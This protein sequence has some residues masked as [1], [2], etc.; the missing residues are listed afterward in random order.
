M[1]SLG[2]NIEVLDSERL[3]SSSHFFGNMSFYKCT[4]G[5]A[6]IEKDGKCFHFGFGAHILTYETIS[7][8]FNE[9][10]DDIEIVCCKITP[11][12]TAELDP[13]LSNK[14]WSVIYHSNPS[15]CKVSELTM[16]DSIF[17][18]LLILY[19]VENM[20]MKR[21]LALHAVI[22]YILILYNLLLLHIDLEENQGNPQSS[23]VS[24]TIDRFFNLCSLHNAKE[25]N[26][27]F[28][29]DKLS[30]SQRHLYNI[31][32]KS[33]KQSPKQILDSFVIGTIK[34]LLLTTSLSIQQIAETMEFAD[35][36]TLRQ[37]FVRNVGISPSEYRRKNRG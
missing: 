12:L 29:T 18:H 2:Y 28:Y 37:F 24:S 5:S 33:L 13:F 34:K 21:Q 8:K 1:D 23:H 3:G 17:S 16:L 20:Q 36:S 19:K 32:Q 15:I 14:I 25:H 7:L 22:N 11:S 35:Q 27:S 26:I 6:E 31:T 10:S 9:W 4:H 30:I